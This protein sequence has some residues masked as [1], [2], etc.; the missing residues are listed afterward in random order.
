[1]TADLDPFLTGAW[2]VEVSC[3]GSTIRLVLENHTLICRVA[4]LLSSSP[5]FTELPTQ[6]TGCRVLWWTRTDRELALDTTRGYLYLEVSALT[7]ETRQ[8]NVPEAAPLLPGDVWM[9]LDPHR[10]RTWKF[11]QS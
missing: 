5:A 4:R 6:L 3:L 10:R 9:E 7:V 2:L 11:S 1:M 8:E